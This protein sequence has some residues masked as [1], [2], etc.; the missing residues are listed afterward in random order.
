MVFEGLKEDVTWFIKA[1]V[2]TKKKYDEQSMVFKQNSNN[3]SPI[4]MSHMA[5]KKRFVLSFIQPFVGCLTDINFEELQHFVNP[6]KFR[7]GI[8]V[9]SK[10]AEVTNGFSELNGT[11]SFGMDDT[12][13]DEYHQMKHVE[14]NHTIKEFVQCGAIFSASEIFALGKKEFHGILGAMKKATLDLTS[15]QP[16]SL[17]DTNYI[18]SLITQVA[19]T[20]FTAIENRMF[21]IHCEPSKPAYVHAYILYPETLSSKKS[22]RIIQMRDDDGRT[23]KAYRARF[24]EGSYTAS[25][26][27]LKGLISDDSNISNDTTSLKAVFCW[28]T[29]RNQMDGNPPHSSKSVLQVKVALGEQHSPL[30]EM[31]LEITKLDS[32]ANTVLNDLSNDTSVSFDIDHLDENLANFKETVTSFSIYGENE[33]KI[34]ESDEDLEKPMAQLIK[35]S[36]HR[37]DNDFTDKLWLLLRNARSFSEMKFYLEDLMND[38]VHGSLQPTISPVNNTKLAKAIR[39]LY[40]EEYEDAKLPLKEKILEFISSDASIVNFIVEIGFE[41]MKKDYYHYFINN[42]MALQPTLDKMR[43]KQSIGIV[44]NNKD[45][46]FLWKLHCCLEIVI[47][48]TVYLRLDHDSQRSL[49]SAAIEYY[50]EHQVMS[51]TPVFCLSLLPVYDTLS[52]VLDS[53]TTR[54]PDI[55]KEG[56]MR[57]NKSGQQE[58][59]ITCHQN[60]NSLEDEDV[61]SSSVNNHEKTKNLKS[62]LVL[63]ENVI[64]LPGAA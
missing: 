40:I 18:N 1:C 22:L 16:L 61:T 53:C 28:P 50:T 57:K 4:F 59:C 6:T 19:R 26:N 62:S 14:I 24:E 46:A 27:I 56:I 35:K 45:I 12:L 49:L 31:F 20:H 42:E 51:T 36:F 54:L 47:T 34:D 2:I 63:C 43:G 64:A 5:M 30:N 10:Y 11:D 17:E 25:Y 52:N 39:K 7:N 15:L 48:P 55:W 9:I 32:I 3:M 29:S 33:E 41:K 37:N 44:N 13:N 38:I 21:L 58:V 23:S 60:D 8:L